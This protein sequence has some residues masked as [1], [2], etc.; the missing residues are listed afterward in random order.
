M[1]YSEAVKSP[2]K[3]ELP[4]KRGGLKISTAPDKG[5]LT[6]TAAF[7][8]GQLLQESKELKRKALKEQ[9]LIEVMYFWL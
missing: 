3:A 9:D 1:T 4:L 6:L 5:Q 7:S 2:R 8:A